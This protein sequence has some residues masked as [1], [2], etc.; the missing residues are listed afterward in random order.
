VIDEKQGKNCPK[1]LKIKLNLKH[2]EAVKDMWEG[3]L[4]QQQ[5]AGKHNVSERT[6]R[7][8]HRDSYFKAFLAKTEEKYSRHSS[9]ISRNTQASF[10]LV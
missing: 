1:L 2:R 3:K 7:N 8:W 5:I 6:I 10:L 4:N 9:N